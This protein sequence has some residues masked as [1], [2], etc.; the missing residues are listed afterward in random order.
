MFTDTR[1]TALDYLETVQITPNNS[2]YEGYTPFH[3]N[4][5]KTIFDED[6]ESNED[7]HYI[8]LSSLIYERYFAEPERYA[9]EISFYNHIRHRHQLIMWFEPTPP[10]KHLFEKIDDLLFY[11]QHGGRGTML[12]CY[13]GPTIEIYQVN[14]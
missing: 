8:I 1:L 10:A 5:F 6:F 14:R 7:I 11:A 2:I 12:D 9:D 4:G 3:P 13:I